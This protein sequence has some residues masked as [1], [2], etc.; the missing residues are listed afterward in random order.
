MSK[1]VQRCRLPVLATWLGA[2]L[3]SGAAAAQGVLAQRL[4]ERAAAR[5]EALVQTL[6]LDA[7]QRAALAQVEATRNA[8][9]LQLLTDL[10]PLVARV[11]ADLADPAA[12]LRTTAALVQAT[13]DREL[14]AHRRVVDARLD[15]FYD[16]LTPAQQ[17]LVR[18][19]LSERLVALEKLREALLALAATR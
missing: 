3:L 6:Q 19:E 1:L 17:A 2:L 11:K 5:H 8:F 10:P 13:V 18:A 9:L 4:V 14:A 12:D 7:G 16:V 15:F